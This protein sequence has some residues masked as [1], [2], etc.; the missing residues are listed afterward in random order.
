LS[1]PMEDCLRYGAAWRMMSH[2][3]V[4]RT[5]T[6]GQGEPRNAEETPPGHITQIAEQMR[7]MRNERMAE[8]ARRLAA[9]Y[10]WRNPR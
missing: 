4:K 1:S 8:E 7:R 3:E 10:P 2:R 9:E 6:E 5:F